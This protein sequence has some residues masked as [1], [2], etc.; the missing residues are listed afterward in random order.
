[1]AGQLWE[2]TKTDKGEIESKIFD[3]GFPFE[4]Q[5]QCRGRKRM[6]PYFRGVNSYKKEESGLNFETTTK[7]IFGAAFGGQPVLGYGFFE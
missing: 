1:M 6:A 5:L 2:T 3:K 4:N 7:E